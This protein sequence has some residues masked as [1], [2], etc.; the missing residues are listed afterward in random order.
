MFVQNN[1][2]KNIV[3][4][5]GESFLYFDFG[6]AENLKRYGRVDPPEYNL[7]LVTAPVY[8]VHADN[9]PFAPLE[10]IFYQRCYRE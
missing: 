6:P 2:V 4:F 7:T 5:T 10:V 3:L 1:F 8:L 9:D